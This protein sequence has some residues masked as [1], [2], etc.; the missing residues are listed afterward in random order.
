M[1]AG[2]IPSESMTCR[3]IATLP[4]AEK[5]AAAGTGGFSKLSQRCEE[6]QGNRPK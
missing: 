1:V 6:D 5:S 2:D 3:R 4:V